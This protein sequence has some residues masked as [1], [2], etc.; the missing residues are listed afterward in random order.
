MPHHFQ[1]APLFFLSYFARDLYQGVDSSFLSALFPKVDVRVSPYFFNRTCGMCGDC[2]VEQFRDLKTPM[3]KEYTS[4]DR[5]KY[6][7]MWMVPEETCLEGMLRNKIKPELLI[8]L[9]WPILS[10][11][12]NRKAVPGQQSTS[13]SS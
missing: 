11:L 12:S 9:S 8:T 6:G 4:R 2:N 3:G 1:Y 10:L 13:K 5:L 7:N